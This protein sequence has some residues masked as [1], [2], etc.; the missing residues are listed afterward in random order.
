LWNLEDAIR[1][2]ERLKVF[3]QEFINIAR[4]IYKTN[5]RR[6]KIKREINIL[7]YSGIFEEKSY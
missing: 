3:D 7:N 5:D 6:S 4:D 1:E 2:K